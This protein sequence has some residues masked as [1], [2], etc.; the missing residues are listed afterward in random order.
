M[1]SQFTSTLVFEKRKERKSHRRR[2]GPPPQLSL[3]V[4]SIRS[5]RRGQNIMPRR[6]LGFSLRN[7]LWFRRNS[8][9]LHRRFIRTPTQP[10]LFG[11]VAVVI[12][13]T[14]LWTATTTEIPSII[15]Q[16]AMLCAS[17]ATSHLTHLRRAIKGPAPEQFRRLLW[18]GRRWGLS[19]RRLNS[20]RKP[21]RGLS[22]S[23]DHERTWI[24]RDIRI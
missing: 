16:Q 24:P 11:K 22:N 19:C 8:R 12:V 23:L 3:I 20:R 18:L 1:R 4:S 15:G 2:R 14:T 17:R 10:K 13:S 21:S 9:C 5:L 7:R 6:S